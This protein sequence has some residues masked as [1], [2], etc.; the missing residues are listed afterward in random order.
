MS[1]ENQTAEK[2]L[3]Q[4]EEDF[5]KMA[6]S[7][8]TYGGFYVG[9]YEA[10]YDETS[11]VSQKSK[12]V[13]NA[14]TVANKGGDRWYGLYKHLRTTVGSLNSHMIWGCQYDQ[15]IKF[16][17]QNSDSDPET[18]HQDR[19]IRKTYSNS[20]SV[21][22]D[23]FENIYDLEGNYKEFTAEAYKTNTRTSR[24]SDYFSFEE[25]NRYYPASRRGG[26]YPGSFYAQY[27][28]RAS[29]YL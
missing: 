14:S 21:P 27:G 23:V 19:N 24:G 22:L 13:M 26:W 25:D 11:Y 6:K 16:I 29:L 8:A 17:K 5:K 18:G 3:E 1:S 10:C 4:L 20:G 2:F 7:V 12:T 28:T 9:R 15:L